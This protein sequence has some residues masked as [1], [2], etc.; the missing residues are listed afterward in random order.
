M[1]ETVI[2]SNRGRGG[3]DFLAMFIVVLGELRIEA[4]RLVS[5]GGTIG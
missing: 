4:Q 5:E 3:T 2:R 1:A